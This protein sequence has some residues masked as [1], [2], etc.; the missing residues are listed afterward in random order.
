MKAP[1]ARTMTEAEKAALDLI[2]PATAAGILAIPIGALYRMIRFRQI[3]FYKVRGL[4]LLNRADVEAK[5]VG[6]EVSTPPLRMR[7]GATWRVH[8]A[9]DCLTSKYSA[10]GE[11]CR[12]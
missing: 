5:K 7:Q 12:P 6:R 4:L 10:R 2:D 1:E 3:D 8:G 11:K 9:R